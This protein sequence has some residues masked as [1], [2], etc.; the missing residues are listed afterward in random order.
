MLGLDTAR[1]RANQSPSPSPQSKSKYIVH[2]SAHYTA[3]C[4]ALFSAHARRDGQQP[5][6]GSGDSCANICGCLSH[7][8]RLGG[9]ALSPG[10]SHRFECTP[11]GQVFEHPLQTVLCGGKPSRCRWHNRLHLCGQIHPRWLHLAV[12][13]HEQLGG[14]AHLVCQIVLLPA[15]LV[16]PL[17]HDRQKPGDLGLAKRLE[18]HEPQRIHRLVCH[19]KTLLWLGGQWLVEPPRGRVA[20]ERGPL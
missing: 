16:C 19:P 7:S 13:E 17:G 15:H 5:V 4:S 8:P 6:G 20:Q 3:V 12:G 14:R 18:G 1:P 10:R 9:G 2:F 11:H